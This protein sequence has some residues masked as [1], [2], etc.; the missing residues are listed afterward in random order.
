MGKKKI[1]II[2]IVLAVLGI[3]VYVAMTMGG[4][5]K[6][7]IMH[8]MSETAKVETITTTVNAKGE[9]SLLN[10]ESIYSNIAAEVEK[11]YVEK[12]DIVKKGDPLIRYKLKSK[13]KIEK[14]I[15]DAELSLS[16][17]QLTLSSLRLP[18]TVSDA[19]LES[20]RQSVVNAE[21]LIKD[22][23]YAISQLERDIDQ[24][25][26]KAEDA[27]ATLDKINVL[28]ASGAAPKKDVENAEED[29]KSNETELANLVY[30]K[31]QK[32]DNLITA[33]KSL[34]S[35]E[36][37]Y[38]KLK[39]DYD[40]KQSNT[41]SQNTISIAEQEILVEKNKLLLEDLKKDLADFK[42]IIYSPIDATVTS[43]SVSEGEITPTDKV[44]ME[45]ADVEDYIIKVDV[46]ERNASK[47]ELGQKAEIEGPVLGKDVVFGKVTKIGNIADLKQT[48]SGTERVVSVEIEVEKND[49]SD[50]LKPG[51]SL[52]AVITTGVYEN[53]VTVPILATIPDKDGSAS[54]LIINEDNTLEKRAVTL[55]VY[56]GMVVEA[57]GISAGERIVAQ[58]T[59][60]MADGMKVTVINEEAAAP[61][62]KIA[63]DAQ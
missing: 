35:S 1:I 43:L 37:Q 46:N 50:L 32:D 17:S 9:V 24:Q 61:E 16:G 59:M 57:T 5:G 56:S 21:E 19:E 11:V 58:P 15:K 49:I 34:S 26:Q 8:V 10:V 12:N 62:E 45:L 52:E 22:T 31:Q 7:I 25:K 4:S 29:L 18:I 38:S 48:N 54:V 14:Q 2:I 30:K 13:E 40:R 36:I 27:K 60:D 39:S 51:F 20:A 33:Q 28:Y 6:E 23:V 41:E 47:I 53:V 63:G 44:L 42:E 3:G 55:G